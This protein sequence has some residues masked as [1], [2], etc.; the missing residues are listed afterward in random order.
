[1][2]ISAGLYYSSHNEG[3]D[4]RKPVVLIHDAASSHQAWPPEIRRLSGQN[5]YALDLPGH[6]NSDGIGFQSIEAYCESVL[7]FMASLNLYHTVLI[8]H[9]MGAAIALT[10]AL[11]FPQHVAGLGLISGGS[12]FHLSDT[13]LDYLSNASTRPV[14]IQMLE[15]LLVSPA[16]SIRDTSRGIEILRHARP[17]VLYGDWKAYAQ[18]DLTMRLDALNIPSYVACGQNDRLTPPGQSRHLNQ[19]LANARLEIM[20]DSGHLLQLE[21]PHKLALSLSAFLEDLET[22]Y[23]S[24]PLPVAFPAHSQDSADQA[25]KIKNEPVIPPVKSRNSAR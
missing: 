9:G 15:R 8:G 5:V 25:E 13:L 16:S 19:V 24:Y 17:G 11:D 4:G 20:P 22:W 3:H 7:T 18:F 23:H 2:P 14:G 12:F 1:M 6:G 10:L 21:Q